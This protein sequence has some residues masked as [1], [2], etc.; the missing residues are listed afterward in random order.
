LPERCRL[1]KLKC[2]PPVD[3]LSPAGVAHEFRLLMRHFI[4]RGSTLV[5]VQI[6]QRE[7]Y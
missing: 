1:A 7:R 2:S 4:R 3:K 6:E 5:L